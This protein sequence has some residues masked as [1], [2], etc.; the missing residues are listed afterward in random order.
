MFNGRT[1]PNGADDLLSGWSLSGG[2][3]IFIWSVQGTISASGMA[4][5]PAVGVPAVSG[6]L[7][8]A[9]CVKIR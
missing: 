2:A 8:W 9:H 3:G 6:A 1:Y 7:T 4:A 5:G